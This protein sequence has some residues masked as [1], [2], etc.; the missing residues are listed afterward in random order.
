[1]R[2][3]VFKRPEKDIQIIR[4]ATG[5]AVVR[6][7]AAYVETPKVLST[8]GVLLSANVLEVKVPDSP[9][10]ELDV[11]HRFSHY[12]NLALEQEVLFLTEQYQKVVDNLVWRLPPGKKEAVVDR[13]D[14]IIRDIAAGDKPFVTQQDLERILKMYI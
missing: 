1:M 12:Y 2:T 9:D 7:Y 8:G 6:L 5:E 10:L 14:R 11:I 4:L 3:P 13:A